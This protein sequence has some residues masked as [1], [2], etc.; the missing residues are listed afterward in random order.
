[1]A[2]NP[3]MTNS[4][5]NAPKGFRTLTTISD[6]S[7]ATANLL[8]AHFALRSRTVSIPRSLSLWSTAQSSY[9][10][11][12]NI[13]ALPQD[14]VTLPLSQ[15]SSPALVLNAIFD[16]DAKLFFDGP[17][18]LLFTSLPEGSKVRL[19]AQ[20]VT[21]LV[22][23]F[24]QLAAAL[25]ES[26]EAFVSDAMFA[27]ELEAFRESE[28]RRAAMAAVEASTLFERCADISQ[29]ARLVV[30]VVER[31]GDEVAL[32]EM[33]EGASDGEEGAM[34]TLEVERP[35]NMGLPWGFSILPVN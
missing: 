7:K 2:I 35:R 8:T 22:L 26:G 6:K 19:L 3:N 14:P 33:L 11:T 10:T 28:E 4:I 23:F 17:G 20:A 15:R 30:R 16:T 34:M 24:R 9:T 18:A 27:R 5:Q 21:G 32:A 1:M 12:H 25:T 13:F 29:V 31:V